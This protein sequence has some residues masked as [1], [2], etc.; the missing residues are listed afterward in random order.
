M[1]RVMISWCIV[2]IALLH[3]GC[4]MTASSTTEAS[5]KSDA[6]TGAWRSKIQFTTGSFASVKDLEFMFVFNSGGTMTESSNYDASPPV[7]P[8]YGVWRRLGPNRYEAKYAYFWTKP[9]A[10]FD[11]IAKGGGW[12]PGGHGVLTEQITLSD[13]GN[14]YTSTISYDAF[15]QAGK[16]TESGSLANGRGVRLRL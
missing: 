14:S 6:L 1:K 10:A 13:D 5:S 15:D 7:P 11:D 9:P 16:P 3:N 8:A 12:S 2:A 4:T